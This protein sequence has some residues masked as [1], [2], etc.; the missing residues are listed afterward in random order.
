M[1]TIPFSIAVEV[2]R[3]EVTDIQKEPYAAVTLK[4]KA[5]FL[6]T[7]MHQSKLQNIGHSKRL[8]SSFMGMF[9]FLRSRL[10]TTILS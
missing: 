1:F 4:A 3:M 7:E 8:K 6:V 5:F 2:E 10:M 9:L